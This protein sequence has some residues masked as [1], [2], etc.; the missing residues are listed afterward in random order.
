VANTH[1]P[2]VPSKRRAYSLDQPDNFGRW[3]T[4]TSFPMRQQARDCYDF[5]ARAEQRVSDSVGILC[6]V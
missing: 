3:L 5:A 2:L 4:E 1:R 6:S